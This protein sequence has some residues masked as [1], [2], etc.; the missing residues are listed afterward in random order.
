VP[1]TG[2]QITQLHQTIRCIHRRIGIWRGSHTLT[3]GWSQRTKSN[4]I[5]PDRLLFGHF[6][7][8]RKKLRH[9]R[10]RTIG[11]Y[12][13]NHTLATLPHLDKR[14]IQNLHRPR[15][16]V[17]LEIATKTKP[18]HSQMARRAPRL[19]LHTPPHSRKEPHGSRRPIVTPRIQHGQKRQPTNGHASRTTLYP[20]H[21]R[22]LPQF[23]RT[24]HYHRSKQQLPSHERMGKHIPYQ[25]SRQPRHPILARHLRTSTRHPP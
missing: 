22:R 15:K 2:P 5:S 8:D 10:Q 4:Q 20:C 1:T 12:E 11:H 19:Q 14:T 16:P 24:L 13:S 23:H 18:T 6:H 9:L 7:R 3:R 25:T 21:R 17:T